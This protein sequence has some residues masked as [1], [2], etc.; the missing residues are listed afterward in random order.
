MDGNRLDTSIRS[1]SELCT[2]RGFTRFLGGLALTASLAVYGPSAADSKGKRKKK[3]KKKRKGT[4]PTGPTILA[5]TG[6][7]RKTITR[8]FSNETKITIPG[9]G[10][11]IGPAAPYNTSFIE[12]TGFTNGRI[13][14]VNVT[15]Q[16]F[17]HEIPEDVDILLTAE[18][19]PGQNALVM[20]DAGGLELFPESNLILTLDDQ[21]AAPLSE[22][23]PLVHGTFKPANYSGAGPDDF[24]FPA[25]TPTGNAALSVFNGINPNGIWYLFVVDD[26]IGSV[27]NIGIG[28]S[29]EIK[30][31]VDG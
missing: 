15:L 21:A 4:N 22:A 26:F 13:L 25:P 20:S 9:G 8:T 16:W 11:T 24:P 6:P 19:L 17:N 10:L 7:V 23:G 2:R 27:G 12:V 31:E 30:A 18:H 28:W 14:D 29:L 5:P 1:L 3:R